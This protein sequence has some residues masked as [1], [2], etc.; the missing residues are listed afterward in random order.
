MSGAVASDDLVVGYDGSPS[1][2]D[3]LAL[4]TPLA[5]LWRVGIR[6]VTVHHPVV[7]G[8]SR[9]ED[10]R[11]LAAATCARDGV[12]RLGGGVPS[13]S[14]EQRSST[15][16]TG[17]HSAAVARAGLVVGRPR[18]RLTD[19]G[20]RR[21]VVEDAPVAVAIARR[22]LLPRP[23]FRHVVLGLVD[24]GTEALDVLRRFAQRLYHH[25]DVA[26]TVAGL[27]AAVSSAVLADAVFE[28]GGA[29]GRRA[30]STVLPARD[31]SGRWDGDELLVCV[32]RPRGAH[33]HQG[34]DTVERVLLTEDGP[35]LLVLP[36][37][38]VE[39]SPPAPA[40]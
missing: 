34:P 21:T 14:G 33:G 38:S 3:A 2:L 6:V 27:D 26:V 12:R 15:V 22:G 18:H 40:G 23:R 29:I 5:R 8:G 19:P 7:L 20:S 24:D 32:G 13:S 30:R 17:L 28:L 9:A 31:A 25:H 16:V 10:D 11:E 35:S 1:S 39:V 37:P 4:A 36:P